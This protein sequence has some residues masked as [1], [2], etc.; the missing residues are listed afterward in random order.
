MNK[1]TAEHILEEIR[2][3]R[4]GKNLNKLYHDRPLQEQGIDSLDFSGIL[5]NI[6]EKFEI[7]IQEEDIKELQTI[8]NIVEFVNSKIK[9]P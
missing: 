7:E 8:D 6:E 5:F 9:S 4:L 3:A 1:V 2:K